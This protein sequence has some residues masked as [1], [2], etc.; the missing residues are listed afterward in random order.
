MSA[1]EL[2]AVIGR[3]WR[4]PPL[5]QRAWL[6]NGLAIGAIVYLALA[7]WSIDVD[8]QRVY[9]GLDRGVQFIAAFTSP[10]FA[11]RGSALPGR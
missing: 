10:D 11:T 3:P 5:I 4:K 1:T 2:D 7:I 9:E 6:R 8:W